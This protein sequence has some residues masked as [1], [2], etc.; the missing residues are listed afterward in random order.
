M[1]RLFY[2]DNI[3]TNWFKYQFRMHDDKN[4]N[5][6]PLYERSYPSDFWFIK[7]VK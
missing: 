4:I 3:N 5:N 2:Q 7:E 6:Y 1:K